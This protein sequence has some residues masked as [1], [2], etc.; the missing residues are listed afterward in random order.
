MS[1]ECIALRNGSKEIKSAVVCT[2]MNL[3]ELLKSSPI[4]FI[5]FHQKLK[6]PDYKMFG[7]T[8]K[9]CESY[10]LMKDETIHQ[11]VKNVAISAIQGEEVNAYLIN[12]F[13]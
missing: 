3:Q 10:G 12:P 4:A 8:P 5:E 9:I 13:E 2:F 7:N 6:N 11:T 1:D